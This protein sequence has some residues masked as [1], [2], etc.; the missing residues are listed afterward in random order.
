MEE[1]SKISD[2]KKEDIYSEPG[3]LCAPFIYLLEAVAFVIMLLRKEIIVEKTDAI[4]QSENS[5][6]PKDKMNFNK[7][8]RASK[9]GRF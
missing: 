3:C 5:C 1:T 6:F 7:Q 8:I 4:D 9:R 2:G